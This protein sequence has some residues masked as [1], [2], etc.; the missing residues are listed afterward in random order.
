MKYY[1]LN[2]ASALV[3]FKEATILGQA[4][5][6]GLYFPVHIPKHPDAL[7]TQIHTLS[8]T[9]LAFRVMEPFVGDAIPANELYQIVSETVNFPL[10]LK[11][12]HDHIASLELY[13]GPSF[14]FKDVGARF[15]SRCLSFFAESNP[16]KITILVA[17][18]GD[19]GGAVANGF[20][21]V[22][23]IEVIILYPSG[24]VSRVQELQ[25]TTCGENITALEIDG[26]FDDCQAMVKA[27]FADKDITAKMQLSSANSINVARWLSQQIYYFLAYQQWAT[28]TAPVIAVPSGNFGNLCAGIMAFK[29]GLPVQHFIAA[30]NVNDAVPNYLHTG[31]FLAKPTIPTISNAMDVGNPSNFSRIME[32]LNH[33]HTAF[34]H[35]VTGYTI[36]DETTAQTIQEVYQQYGYIL[37]PHGAVAYA[38]LQQ[39]QLHH[40][41]AK[42]FILETA[43]PVKFPAAV[44]AAIG[45]E[46]I[47]PLAAM[48]LFT[49]EKRSIPMLNEYA[50]FKDY[51]LSR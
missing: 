32:L 16:Q 35:L 36:S 37:D 13:H 2:K 20:L 45:V 29:T 44:K 46:P 25:L 47:I 22:D 11:S 4:P 6:K 21:G 43:D 48:G 49:K 28:E 38:A 3:D 9:D 30:C 33:D 1:S 50:S 18:S 23:G 8:K 34:T 19:T 12:I 17:T 42:G 15:M 40:A 31:I 5:D 7:F 24:K 51:L 39:Y 41:N 14:A 26:S 10:P 27:A